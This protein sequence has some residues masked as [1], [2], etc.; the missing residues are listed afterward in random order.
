MMSSM[1]MRPV[2]LGL[3]AGVLAA[4][5]A[6]GAASPDEPRFT[7]TADLVR[8]ANYRE[9]T[10]LTSGLGMT[11]DTP[12]TEIGA[13]AN[14]TFTN[15]YVTPAAYRSF[16]KTGH[17]PDRTMFVLEARSSAT[18]GSINRGGRFQTTLGGIEV[19][20]MD[21]K[22]FPKTKWGY[23]AFGPDASASPTAKPLPDTAPCFTCHSQHGAV[24][25]TFVQ[26][27]PTLLEVAKRLGTLSP[28]HQDPL[29]PAAIR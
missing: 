21:R 16:M 14:Q 24:D 5:G 2:F 20:V 13:S 18:E 26:F 25:A 10:F 22:R 3:V 9:W 23:F 15:V 4:A 1:P 27:Y 8:P 7:K 17:W 19:E 28:S 12:G 11:Y 6:V 29:A